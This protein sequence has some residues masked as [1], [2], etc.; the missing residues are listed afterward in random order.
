MGLDTLSSEA[1][2]REPW[3]FAAERGLREHSF[4]HGSSVCKIQYVGVMG[5]EFQLRMNAS[6]PFPLNSCV[7]V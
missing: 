1:W 7:P 6:L 3:G 2:L 4:L 5:T